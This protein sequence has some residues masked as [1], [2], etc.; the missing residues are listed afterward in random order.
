MRRIRSSPVNSERKVSRAR[1]EKEERRRRTW[2]PLSRR[3]LEKFEGDDTLSF[4]DGLG[5]LSRGGSGN[6]EERDQAVEGG[7]FRGGEGERDGRGIGGELVVEL[8]ELGAE[9]GKVRLRE[10][11]EGSL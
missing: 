6:E 4:A 1:E 11:E 5:R 7:D 3:P 8:A 9:G 10:G 2:K